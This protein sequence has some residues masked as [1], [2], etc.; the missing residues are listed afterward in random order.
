MGDHD[1]AATRTLVDG[2]AA[3]ALPV[4][5]RGLLYGDGVFRTLRVDGGRCWLWA[6]HLRVLVRDAARIGLALDADRLDGLAADVAMLT[7]ADS[8]ILR[9]TVTRGSARRGYAP[10]AR[11]RPRILL[12]FSPGPV[13][14]PD[15]TGAVLRVAHTRA[16]T[17]PALAGVKHLGRLEQVL[18]AAEMDDAELFDMLMLGADDRILCGTRCN[19]FLRQGRRLV[20]PRLD[21]GGVAGVVREQIIGG[22][23]AGLRALVDE[24]VEAPL[25]LDDLATADEAFVTNAVIAVRALAMVRDEGGRPLATWAAPGAASACLLADFADAL[26]RTSLDSPGDNTGVNPVDSREG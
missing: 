21:T 2:V 9:I 18:A 13:P 6:E 10:P 23:V 22:R 11:A 14:A 19:L 7:A 1:G 15:H 16:A 20:T 24:V 8:G 26:G 5:D 25:T 3:T 12:A 17:S 4:D